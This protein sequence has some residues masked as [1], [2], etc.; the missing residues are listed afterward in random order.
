MRREESVGFVCRPGAGA[1]PDCER[2]LPLLGNIIHQ[3]GRPSARY[4]GGARS[5]SP[6]S[7][8][9]PY[10]NQSMNAKRLHTGLPEDAG[11]MLTLSAVTPAGMRLSR[12]R[13]E[14]WR[15]WL[16]AKQQTQSG[17]TSALWLHWLTGAFRQAVGPSY[18]HGILSRSSQLQQQLGLWSSG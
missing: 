10:W 18:V 2:L 1:C 14:N 15:V 12:G 13:V 9:S 3:G 5:L 11:G 8:Q 4:Q 7:H 6:D 17:L 16:P